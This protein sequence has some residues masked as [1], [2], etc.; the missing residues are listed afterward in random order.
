MNK[1]T[2]STYTPHTKTFNVVRIAGGQYADAHKIWNLL[3]IGDQVQLILN[4]S[5]YYD[6]NAVQVWYGGDRLG[7]V[8]KEAGT[9][10]EIFRWMQLGGEYTAT[11]SRKDPTTHPYSQLFM[12]VEFVYYVKREK[13]PE[14]SQA[15]RVIRDEW[16]RE[17]QEWYKERSALLRAQGRTKELP[18]RPKK[19]T[20]KPKS[21]K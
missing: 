18:K 12:K 20:S 16:E 3:N 6:Q 11:L 21:Q 10:V 7:Y 2:E 9:N 19:R 8:A 13:Q 4:P 17:F 5:N 14:L 1:S 15:F